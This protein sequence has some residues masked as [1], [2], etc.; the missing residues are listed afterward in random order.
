MG[1]IIMV[2]LPI[3]KKDSIITIPVNHVIQKINVHGVIHYTETF[4]TKSETLK[5][6]MFFNSI[7]GYN[8]LINN[9]II[10]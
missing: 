7:D 6:E 1:H 5:R 4:E 2:P 9:K 10:G 8:W 3:L